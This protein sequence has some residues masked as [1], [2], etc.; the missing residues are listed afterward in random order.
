MLFMGLLRQKMLFWLF[1]ITI[2]FL[3]D[4]LLKLLK[5]IECFKSLFHLQIEFDNSP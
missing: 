5:F 2:K 1:L 4:N 3:E